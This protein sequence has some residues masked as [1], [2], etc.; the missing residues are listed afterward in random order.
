MTEMLVK[1]YLQYL[2]VEKGLAEN[3]VRS[4]ERDLRDYAEFLGDRGLSE[5]TKE[6][7]LGF[8]DHLSERG[9]SVPSLA[10]HLAAVRGFHKYLVM[11]RHAPADPTEHIETPRGW[12]RL[13]KTLNFEEVELLLGQPDASTSRGARDK[14][15]L[16]LLYATG[17]R[18][19]ELV[20]IRVQDIELE[21]GHVVVFG[22]GSKERL[23]PLGETAI[24]AVKAYLEGARRSLLQGK[25]SEAL[26]I[27]AKRGQITRQMFWQDPSYARKAE[28]R[29]PFPHLTPLLCNPPAGQWRGPAGGPGH[30]GPCGH[31]GD[32][33]Y[34]LF[35]GNG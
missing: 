10:R 28:S 14:A 25:D 2:T 11:E 23:V 5:I 22:K 27:S 6:D 13:P 3:T 1:E 30:A 21:R 17:L 26:F 33:I 32:Q 8:L 7:V 19:S 31:L 4:Y 24:A 35:P 12:A 34:T 18:V 16:E 15:M 29:R 20:G 9:M